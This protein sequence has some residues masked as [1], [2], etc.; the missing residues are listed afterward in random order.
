[1]EKERD[2]AIKLLNQHGIVNQELS[3]MILAINYSKSYLLDQLA[4][5]TGFSFDEYL[6]KHKPYLTEDQISE[7]KDRGFEFGSHSIDHP[8]FRE[9][10]D[11][12]RALQIS[13]SV[14]FLDA[15]NLLTHR[16]F[17]FPYNSNMVDNEFLVTLYE[18]Y[19]IDITFGSNGIKPDSRFHHFQR[20]HMD[21]RHGSTRR[22]LITCYAKGLAKRV[23]GLR[24]G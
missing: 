3:K 21:Y 8:H 1:M 16:A 4:E 17:A 14:E 19:R 15:K 20:F 9:L 24:N 23:V 13:E 11:E 7:M 18:K 10:N 5:N 12:E 2:R 22:H 6:G